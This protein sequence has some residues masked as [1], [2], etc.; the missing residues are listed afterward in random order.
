[1]IKPI[2]SHCQKELEEYGAILLGPPDSK[3]LVR[4]HHICKDCYSKV[5][6]KVDRELPQNPIK[7][8]TCLGLTK[9]EA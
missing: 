9:E 5:V 4:K 6:I 3:G 1:M 2:C 8:T 7:I